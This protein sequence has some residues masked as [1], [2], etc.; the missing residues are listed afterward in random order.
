MDGENGENAV[1]EGPEFGKIYE[2]GRHEELCNSIRVVARCSPDNM[3]LFVQSLKSIRDG[4]AC[5]AM[6]ANG[7]NEA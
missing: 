3:L 7:T 6:T 5:V 4:K 1:I 2:E